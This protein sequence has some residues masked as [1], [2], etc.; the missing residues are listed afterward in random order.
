MKKSNK[1]IL[2]LMLKSAGFT[3]EEF[4][5]IR[6]GSLC[7]YQFEAYQN[8]IFQFDVATDS[9]EDA[10]RQIIEEIYNTDNVH[11]TTIYQP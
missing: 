6:N 9:F 7:G 8:G 1:S 11:F 3:M 2:E 10:V 5:T 4:E